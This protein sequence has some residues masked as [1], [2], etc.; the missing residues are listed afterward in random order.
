MDI[1]LQLLE[2]FQARGSDGKIYKVMGYE[3]LT[4]DASLPGALDQWASTGT[5]EYR[6]ADGAFVDAL[7]DGSMRIHDTGVA[8]A[9]DDGADQPAAPAAPAKARAPRKR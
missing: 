2:S 1:K 6:L 7:N 9:R 8:L 4:R 5:N 3:R